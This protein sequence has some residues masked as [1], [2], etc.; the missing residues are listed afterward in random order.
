MMMRRWSEMVIVP[1]PKPR[2][3]TVIFLI[4]T[5]FRLMPVLLFCNSKRRETP[6]LLLHQNNN[7]ILPDFKCHRISHYANK[8][9]SQKP[10]VT[11]ENDKVE[12][13][14]EKEKISD[15]LPIF[16]D[17]AHEPMAGLKSCEHKNL[18]S[19]QS[20]SISDE[21]CLQLTIL[22][23]ENRSSLEL[24]SQFEKDSKNVLNKNEFSG[25]LN[26]LDIG[27]Y[28]LGLGS[29]VSIQE[30]PDEEQNRYCRN[31]NSHCRIPLN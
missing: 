22:L 10:L 12:T 2:E 25:P 26:A 4:G 28:D 24:I 1:S 11:L 13:E 15:L 14:P 7:L 21:S 6:T 23:P 27:A 9:Q 8:C 19:S 29:F 20:E 3:A 5:S 17:Y 16:D 31:R 30:G 18:F